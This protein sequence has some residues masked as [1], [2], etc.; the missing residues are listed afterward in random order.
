MLLTAGQGHCGPTPL[1]FG[2]STVHK[3]ARGRERSNFTYA[4]RL[5]LTRH[6]SGAWQHATQD[7]KMTLQG[8]SCDQLRWR[9]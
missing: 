9:L 5:S 4:P 2:A 3:K 6:I 7:M 1:V 8:L